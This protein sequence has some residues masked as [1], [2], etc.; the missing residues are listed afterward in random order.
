[1]IRAME[2]ISGPVKTGE[3]GQPRH[4][5]KQS[6]AA[7]SREPAPTAQIHSATVVVNVK[8]QSEEQ[9]TCKRAP[10]DAATAPSGTIKKRRIDP[11][12]EIIDKGLHQGGYCNLL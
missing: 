3:I 7:G 5:D 12:A 9:T 6:A 8:D 2:V 1:M 10:E 4:I 11:A